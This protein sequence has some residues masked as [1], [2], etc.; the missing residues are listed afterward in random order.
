MLLTK[1][2]SPDG[3]LSGHFSNE[4]LNMKDVILAFVIHLIVVIVVVAIIVTINW[5]IATS[6]LPDWFKYSL[7][8]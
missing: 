6:D 3:K 8:R 2:I 1:S 7:L 4:V 5:L